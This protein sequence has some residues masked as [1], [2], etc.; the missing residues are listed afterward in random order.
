MKTYTKKSEAIEEAQARRA[1]G[2]TVKVMK[3]IQWIPGSGANV[4]YAAVR[5]FVMVAA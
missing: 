3:S 2:E 4:G 5:Y 1:V